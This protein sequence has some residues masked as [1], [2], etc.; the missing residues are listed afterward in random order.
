[1]DNQQVC[2]RLNSTYLR[3]NYGYSSSCSMNMILKNKLTN[4][5]NIGHLSTI[6]RKRSI[7]WDTKRTSTQRRLFSGTKRIDIDKLCLWN[8]VRHTYI[9]CK[10]PY[11]LQCFLNSF[12]TQFLTPTFLQNI[13]TE[14][15]KQ[16]CTR[17]SSNSLVAEDLKSLLECLDRNNSNIS[18][19]KVLALTRY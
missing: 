7:L 5:E 18:E 6:S 8:G 16:F 19:R 11:L 2:D 15:G 13:I 12:V 4:F 3:D 10:A 9:Q 17:A 1:M 14:S